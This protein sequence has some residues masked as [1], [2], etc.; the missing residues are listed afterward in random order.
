MSRPKIADT[1]VLAAQW[2]PTKNGTLRPEDISGGSAKPIWWKCEKDPKHEWQATPNDRTNKNVGCIYCSGKGVSDKNRLTIRHPDIAIEWHPSKN[3]PLTPDEVSFSSHEIVWWQCQKNPR[4]E[5]EASVNNRTKRKS[6]SKRSSGCPHCSGTRITE[7]NT[8]A[9]NAPELLEEWHPTKNTEFDPHSVHRGS[10]KKAWWQCRK[11]PRHEWEAAILSRSRKKKPAGCPYCA[12][13]RVLPEQSLASIHPEIAALLH[14]TENGDLRADQLPPRSNRKIWWI[15][16]KY[17]ELHPWKAS[18]DQLVRQGPNCPYCGNKKACSTNSLAAICPEPAAEWHPELNGN[19]TP[20]DVVWGSATRAWWQCLID[21]D[22]IWRTA[23]NNRTKK[24]SGCP[25]CIIAPRS[26]EEI[27]LAHELTS[28]MEFGLDDHK[29]RCGT[30]KPL[31]V[32]IV[33]RSKKIAIE[34]DG[35]YWHRKKYKADQDKTRL[36]SQHGWTVLRIREEPLRAITDLDVLVSSGN[37][38]KM[39]DDVLKQLAN[40]LGVKMQGMQRYMAQSSLDNAIAAKKH[41]I[42]LQKERAEKRDN[43]HE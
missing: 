41:I 32:D 16:K 14:P 22:H 9:A 1:P 33:I 28:F 29:V 24:G 12:G 26:K 25:Y 17:P 40:R 18:P 27:Y 13:L 7:E 21:P 19:L 2:H 15:C 31:D 11:N 8:L 39:V 23:I 4:H 5:W 38:K 3:S 20:D 43:G 42:R 30:R 34:Y 6:S 10:K 35:Y 37:T 36:L